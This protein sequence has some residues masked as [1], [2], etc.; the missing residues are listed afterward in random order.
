MRRA[1]R[2]TTALLYLVGSTDFHVRPDHPASYWNHSDHHNQHNYADDH[3][4]EHA[5][6]F[7]WLSSLPKPSDFLML[8]FQVV[9]SSSKFFL[10]LLFPVVTDLLMNEALSDEVVRPNMGKVIMFDHNFLPYYRF[11]I[12]Y[13]LSSFDISHFL[14][15]PLR[16]NDHLRTTIPLNTAIMNI[17][18]E[19]DHY[20]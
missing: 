2:T 1:T 19:F 13:I 10:I 8:N 12:F 7:Q 20:A 11:F 17:A 14:K 16:P 3:H 6:Y 4:I 9:N 5:Q 18:C 15:L